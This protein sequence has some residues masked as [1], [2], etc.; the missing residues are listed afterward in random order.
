MCAR[1]SG[2]AAPCA[3]AS[4]RARAG[5]ITVRSAVFAACAL[6]LE[7]QQPIDHEHC[8]VNLAVTRAKVQPGD[9]MWVAV[10]DSTYRRK[11]RKGLEDAF[12]TDHGQKATCFAA[13]ALRVGA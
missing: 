1:R 6:M 4:S 7:L 2:S 11:V 13:R 5:V 3:A 10:S 8:F 9:D 12:A